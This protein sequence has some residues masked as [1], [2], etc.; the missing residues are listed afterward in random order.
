MR[1]SIPP[2]TGSRW[3]HF[4]R[5]WLE[6]TKIRFIEDFEWTARFDD[7]DHLV[8]GR[9]HI[10]R[11]PL[12][13][14]L[15]VASEEQFVIT[16]LVFAND[17]G[18][19]IPVEFDSN[20]HT[21]PEGTVYSITPKV[22]MPTTLIRFHLDKNIREYD[23]Q[24]RIAIADYDYADFDL[25]RHALSLADSKKWMRALKCMQQ[26]QNYTQDNPNV[27][28]YI[29]VLNNE[30]GEV[31]ESK[32]YAL[33]A[34]G[35][36]LVEPAVGAYM[37]VSEKNPTPNVD[38]IRAIQEQARQW[39]LPPTVGILTL[40]RNQRH[41]LRYGNCFASL[42]S[43]IYEVRRHAAARMLRT[44][45]YNYS[46]KNEIILYSSLHI[47]HTGD[48]VEKLPIERLTVTDAEDA[49]LF[50]PVENEKTLHWI[51][52]D[53]E[54]GDVIVWK[55]DVCGRMS[56]VNGNTQYFKLNAPFDPTHP[57]FQAHVELVAPNSLSI[58]MWSSQRD[59]SL[60]FEVSEN[61]SDKTHRYVG[62]RFL[63]STHSGTAYQHFLVNPRV[64]FSSGEFTWSDITAEVQ[65]SSIGTTDNREQLPSPLDQIV[66]NAPGKREALE[67]AF[68][69]IRDK[70]KYA[71]L[72]SAESN[73]GAA[74]RAAKMIESGT[75][76]CKDRAYLLDLVCQRLKM[77]CQYV[78][79]SS[80]NALIVSEL[81][82]HQ[83]D[84]I[85][86]RVRGAGDWKYLDPTN[87]NTPFGTPPHWCQGLQALAMDGT[88][89]IVDIPEDDPQANTLEI[90]QSIDRLADGWLEGSYDFKAR[91]HAGRIV[92]EKWKSL[93]LMMYDQRHAA[94]H[95][96]SQFLPGCAVIDCDTQSDTSRSNLFHVSGRTKVS[97]LVPLRSGEQIALL[98]WGIPFLPL[99]YWR[100][101]QIEKLFSFDFP[102]RVKIVVSISPT[103]AERLLDMTHA[104]PID[105]SICQTS[106][107]VE[108]TEIA[109]TIVRTLQVSRKFVRGDDTAL[110]APSLESFET[111]LSL[112]LTLRSG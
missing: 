58:Q 40:Q 90:H 48:K 71:A 100:V 17:N 62:Q 81:P 47:I 59:S 80:K 57:T 89:T 11:L 21:K 88:G 44:L 24:L 13:I 111:A 18:E 103:V 109:T 75:A 45:S 112:V 61:E 108:A 72:H 16:R 19:D 8:E 10:A 39:E 66:D 29:A 9:I 12:R 63:P 101:M 34:I 86:V 52:P 27:D 104:D 2:L 91:S 32:E 67:S 6:Y 42:R 82:A 26:Y 38:E 43:R 96:M 55:L 53:L 97:K 98:S 83:F 28:Y 95:I 94:Q 31:E 77:E 93:S 76:D 92:N 14:D 3:T 20:V 41:V 87:T 68:Y 23:R 1:A 15:L 85:F 30:L 69:W 50:I 5:R 35:K 25:I 60:T 46:T 22:L 7:D 74:D 105:N 37:S 49:N 56:K 65:R 64:A 78:L 51:L 4:K 36:Q 33:R 99:S 79:V 73:I 70:L 54:P 107:S 110:I 106:E 102:C 84:H